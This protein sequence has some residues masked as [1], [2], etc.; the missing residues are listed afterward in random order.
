MFVIPFRT[1][2]RTALLTSAILVKVICITGFGG[3][4]IMWRAWSWSWGLTGLVVTEDE[5]MIDDGLTES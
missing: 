3:I 4:I 5:L 1:R 2:G